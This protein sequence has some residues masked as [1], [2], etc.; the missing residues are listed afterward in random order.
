MIDHHAV[1]LAARN[2]LLGVEVCTTGAT[3]LTATGTG[4]TRAAGSF[5]TDGFKVG[6]EV[7]PT[8]FADNTPAVILSVSALAITLRST[9]T[10]ETA[11]GGRT[12][13]VGIPP[14]RVWENTD[15]EP[16]DDRWFIDED[17]IPGPT[18]QFTIGPQGHLEHAPIYV[19]KVF[20]ISGSGVGALY[21]VTKEILGVFPPR[22]T[23]TLADSTVVRV[24]S[25]PAPYSSQLM[26]VD[27]GRAV[28]TVSIPLLVRTTNPV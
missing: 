1:L 21:D 19:V 20:G 10:A 11:A 6:M 25:Q 5:I 12:L 7:V 22:Y 15:F 2:R 8:G 4:F 24:R 9:R 27:P 26:Q 18:E 13:T 16:V 14:Y 23:M 3:T 28:V 17:Y